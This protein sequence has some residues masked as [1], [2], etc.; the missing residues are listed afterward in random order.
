M[1]LQLA[2]AVGRGAA[3]Q[4][5]P[6]EV[7]QGTPFAVVVPVDVASLKSLLFFIIIVLFCFG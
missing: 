2:A 5:G 3:A 6:G 1:Q 7:Q 4:E